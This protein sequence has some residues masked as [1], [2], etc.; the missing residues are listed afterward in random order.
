[1]VLKKSRETECLETSEISLSQ[2]LYTELQQMSKQ[3]SGKNI[4][5]LFDQKT[6]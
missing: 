1:M 5:F 2:K 3:T 4:H 6:V